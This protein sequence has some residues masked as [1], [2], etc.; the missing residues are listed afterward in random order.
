MLALRTDT[1]STMELGHGCRNEHAAAKA[2]RQHEIVQKFE[3]CISS[4]TSAIGR[5]FQSELDNEPCFPIDHPQIFFAPREKRHD[6]FY[7]A[8]PRNQLRWEA[9]AGSQG[10]RNYRIPHNRLIA[11]AFMPF[12]SWQVSL[13][14]SLA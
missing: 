6:S 4:E 14:V 13:Q 7:S 10:K 1:L 5:N 2:C 3:I 12:F 9:G 8:A 11:S